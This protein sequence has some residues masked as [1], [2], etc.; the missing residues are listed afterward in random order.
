MLTG[1]H[2]TR[3]AVWGSW[4]MVD[5]IIVVV[6]HV[7]LYKSA[8]EYRILHVRH[9]HRHIL[10]HHHVII[11][12]LKEHDGRSN[13]EHTEDENVGDVLGVRSILVRGGK[14]F[15]DRD[16]GHHTSNETEQDTVNITGHTVVKHKVDKQCT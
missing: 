10:Y 2:D 15:V 13:K 11:L 1:W 3:S 6:N 12:N 4:R 9:R 8:I 14:Q 5:T 7:Y 16:D